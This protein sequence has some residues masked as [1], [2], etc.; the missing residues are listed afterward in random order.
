MGFGQKELCERYL[1]ALS[2]GATVGAVDHYADLDGGKRPDFGGCRQRLHRVLRPLGG[3]DLARLPRRPD[4]LVKIAHALQTHRFRLVI[5]GEEV[6]FHP[7]KAVA[8]WTM[9]WLMDVAASTLKPRRPAP[10]RRRRRIE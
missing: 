10:R 6:E 7:G 2:G 4:A 5:A 9:Q 1:R 3:E 8:A